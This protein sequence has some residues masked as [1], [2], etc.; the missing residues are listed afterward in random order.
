MRAACHARCLP[1]ALAAFGRASTALLLCLLPSDRWSVPA[2][3]LA[4]CCLLPSH[5]VLRFHL[6]PPVVPLAF[7]RN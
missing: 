4:P 2:V 6:L 1:C 3:E 7:C 5:H